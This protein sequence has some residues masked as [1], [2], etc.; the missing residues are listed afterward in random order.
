MWNG[1]RPRLMYSQKFAIQTTKVPTYTYPPNVYPTYA[2]PTDK[3]F[4]YAYPTSAYPAYKFLTYA[5]ATYK[6]SYLCF[7][8]SMRILPLNILPM[9]MLPRYLNVHMIYLSLG[10][11]R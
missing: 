1:L 4:T 7:D 6:Y 3:Y 8:L 10:P 5:N 11:G 2:Y 9:R